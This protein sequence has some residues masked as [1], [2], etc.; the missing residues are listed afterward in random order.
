MKISV[1]NHTQETCECWV[2]SKRSTLNKWKS[3]SAKKRLE[4]IEKEAMES[5][6][7]DGLEE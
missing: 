1:C 3:V 4:K 6:G 7:T 2:Y 5:N